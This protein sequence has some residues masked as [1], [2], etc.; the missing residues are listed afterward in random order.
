MTVLFTFHTKNELV[1]IDKE[2]H[3]PD[4]KLYGTSDLS[5][6]KIIL[7]YVYIKKLSIGNTCKIRMNWGGILSCLFDFIHKLSP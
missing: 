1:I 6:H 2:K 5:F 4:V 7:H 3:K